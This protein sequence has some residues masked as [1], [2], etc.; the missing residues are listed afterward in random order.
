MSV[1]FSFFEKHRWAVY[2]FWI[3]A[4]F[5]LYGNTLSHD[6]V[7]DDDLVISGNKHVQRGLSGIPAVFSHSHTHGAT[8]LED[9][10]YRPLPLTIYAFL[11]ALFG[12]NAAMYHFMN[13]LLYGVSVALLFRLLQRSVPK[14]ATAAVMIIVG[15][16]LV[17]PLHTE[18]VAN[19]KGLEDILQF[20]FLMALL[21]QLKYF[22]ES[23]KTIHLIALGGFFAGSL[24]SKEIAVSFLAVIPL[25]LYVFTPAKAKTYGM[26][27]G[28]SLLVIGLYAALRQAVLADA[29]DAELTILN[30]ALVMAEG[31]ADQ[32]ASALWMQV[33][34]LGLMVYPDALTH[35][36]SY[37]HVS[38]A[39]MG[40]LR[41][42]F[43]VLAG[44]AS[45]ALAGY[46]VWKK[47]LYGFGLAF[48]LITIAV[49]SNLFFL[50]GATMAERF[51]FTA[52]AGLILALVSI[53]YEK[54]PRKQQ[55]LLG[56]VFMA[57][58]LLLSARTFV[59]N[60]DW[61]DADTLFHAD[62]KHAPNST[63]IQKNVGV[64][65]LQKAQKAQVRQ[66]GAEALKRA[67]NHLLK[68][69]ELLPANYE[70][71]YNLG[72]VEQ[73]YGNKAGA[74]DAFHASVKHEPEYSLAY[75]NLGMI[76]FGENDLE[77]AIPNFR[78]AYELNPSVVEIV[79]NMG[80][81]YDVQ[82]DF[83]KA[84]AYY[85]E[86]LAINPKHRNTLSN[87]VRAAR[88]LGDQEKATRYEAQLQALQAGGQ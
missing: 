73:M 83:V 14:L 11:N 81:T 3:V 44:L 52:S 53:L 50:I 23:H 56:W 80:L 30:N 25:Y 26:A 69:V 21:L 57:A 79:S 84:V 13:V 37:S 18:V 63:R 9:A 1:L 2:A 19:A 38:L 8:G 49:V 7:L 54:L 77:N 88:K 60:Q 5:L 48:Y 87:L 27:V 58:I 74:L 70:A 29:R 35:D 40:S 32:V 15:L 46:G 76:Y 64:L 47:Q 39:T 86:A 12:N 33:R 78:K 62:L 59:R 16:F 10:G 17:H 43:G 65:Y 45:I 85:E 55:P 28:C 68:S 61:K 22:S 67:R 42:I 82:N 41:G 75:N 31:T 71:W 20:L 72:V 36:Y 6:F 24:L 51:T 4:A 34:Y 66:V